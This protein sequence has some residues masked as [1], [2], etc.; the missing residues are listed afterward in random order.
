MFMPFQEFLTGALQINETEI[1]TN[2]S[3]GCSWQ[4]GAYLV[5]LSAMSLLK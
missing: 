2:Q 3:G 1:T 4:N 5:E